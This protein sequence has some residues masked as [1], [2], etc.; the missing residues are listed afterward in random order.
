MA[1]RRASGGEGVVIWMLV[2][3]MEGSG[4]ESVTRL[5]S[6]TYPGNRVGNR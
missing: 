3:V 1:G 6:Q 5:A 2:D 4:I